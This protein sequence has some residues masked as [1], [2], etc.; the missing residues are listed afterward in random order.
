MS[1]K[2][3]KKVYEVVKIYFSTP[4]RY[5]NFAT[6]GLGLGQG[7]YRYLFKIFKMKFTFFW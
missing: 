5:E 1:K 3:S 7:S 4:V 2:T 6:Y